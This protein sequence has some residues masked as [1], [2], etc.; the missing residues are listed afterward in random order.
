MSSSD[1]NLLSIGVFLIIVVV[2]ILL[3]VAG[4]ITW[5]LFIP[6]VLLLAGLWAVALAAIRSRNPQKYERSSFSTMASGLCLIAVGGAFYL[7]SFNWLYSLAVI[8]LVVAALA[9]AVALRRK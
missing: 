1:R 4:A 5:Y 2:G 9:I 6:V 7:Y 3:A 8:L